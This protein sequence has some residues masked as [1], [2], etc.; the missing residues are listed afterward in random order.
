MFN[1]VRK[2]RTRFYAM[3]YAKGKL[4]NFKESLSYRKRNAKNSNLCSIC[5]FTQS[6]C[7][8]DE[9]T[10]YCVCE[11]DSVNNYFKII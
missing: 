8:I 9:E 1:C 7:V 11:S 6:C 3:Y 2:N 4:F 5:A 10:D